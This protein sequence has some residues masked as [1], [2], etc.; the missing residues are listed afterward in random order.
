M[1]INLERSRQY[2]KQ[3]QLR[4]LFVEELGWDNYSGSSLSLSV[5][6]KTYTL[7]AIAEKRGQVVYTCLAEDGA[8]PISNIRT[9]IHKEACHYT[10]ENVLV[11]IDQAQTEQVWQWVRRD[12]GKPKVNRFHQFH[13]S[14]S[15]DALLQ[16]LETLAVSFDEEEQLTLVDVTRRTSRAFD[17]DRVTKKFYERFKKE[18][19]LFL[20]FIASIDSQFDREW[21]CSLMLNRLMFI[22]FIQKKGFLDGNTNYLRDRLQVCQK[23]Q[24]QDS[25][26]SFY[27]YFLLK[28]FHS[29]LGSQQRTP[30]LE[31]LL[32]G[33]PYLN[34]GLF[35][36]H[37][38]EQTYPDIQIPDKAFE[39]I[40]DFFDEYQWHL[41]DR[42]LR[43]DSEIN[44]DVLGYI[45]EK[46][47][48]QKQMGAYY[49]K[50]DITEYISK[51][52][53]LPF[54]FDA[55]Q[56]SC[57]IAFQ[58][59]RALWQLL[60]D[61]PDRYIYPAVQK[62]VDLPLPES[63]EVGVLDVTQRQGWNRPAESDYALPT[64]TWRE[65]ISRRQRCLELRQK[66][67]DGELHSI[68]DLITY[69]LDIRQFSQD[70][71][72]NSESPEFLKA[73]YTAICQVSIL[74][75][76]CGSGA[77]L[78]AALNIL[79]PLYDGCLERMQAS[80]DDLKRSNPSHHLNEFD[81]FRQILDRVAQHP[82]RRYFILKSIILN[83]LY[84]VD[85]MEEAT[86]ICKLRL[87]LKLVA[88]MEPQYKQPNFGLEPLP[89]IDFNIQ[90]GNTL[91][92]FASL[93]K[94]RKAIK[95][96]GDQFKL[97]LQHN[98]TR[99]DEN[100]EI[101]DRAF[102]RFRQMQ[103]EFCMDAGEFQDSKK[104]LRQQLAEVNKELNCYLARE[105]G[106]DLNKFTAFEKW[107]KSHQPFHW[108][109]EFYNIISRGGF[110]VIIGNPPYVEYK[111]V[112]N[113]YV[114]RD[115]ATIDCSDLYAFTIERSLELL[116]KS[117]RVG[118]IV[119]ISIVS[120]DGFDSLRKLLTEKKYF[121]W[122]LNFAERPSKL[123]TGVEKRLTIWITFKANE[124]IQIQSYVESYKRWLAEERGHLFS[125]IK[126]VKKT[127]SL[128]LVSNSIPKISSV[129]EG[130]I[131]E[132]LSGQKQ[133]NTFFFKSS[134][135]I[136]YYTRK[137][138]YFVQFYDFIPKIIN[139]QKETIEPSE[140]KIIAFS[141]ETYKNM[142]IS[143]LNSNLFFW[144]FNSYSDVRNVN[145]REIDKF[146]FSMN[147]ATSDVSYRLC[148][149]TNKLMQDFQ[150]NSQEL[151][152]NYGKYGTLTIQSFQPRLSKPIIDE[153]DRVLAQH[154][155]F[156]AEE[157]DF[158]INYDIKY[159]MGQ[160]TGEEE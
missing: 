29:G 123:F 42:P 119:P 6:G 115:F 93:D 50:E 56:K 55:V 44:P 10:L 155:G 34:G 131:L 16:K 13:K 98:A 66:L 114:I 11:Y 62:G 138:R 12:P 135:H 144:F 84:G 32:G 41:D 145:R 43:E 116:Y 73:F 100:A 23:L 149:L 35:E 111:N 139:A 28:L 21:Y 81:D 151:T 103:T 91:V 94:A 14:Q 1:Q 59:D 113:D 22:Y 152:N 132:R 122:S 141:S 2:L 134:Q 95:Q 72:E 15:G 57:A 38:L 136:V 20:E 142:A 96:D 27:R 121:S 70:A 74:D 9:K 143:I 90:A 7:T 108:F 154:Y 129:I 71:I 24:G 112:K 128:N 107:R 118:M 64:E 79:E 68:N 69:N 148:S 75:P 146:R 17:L 102:Q 76:T 37:Q 39:N 67:A 85:I 61:N 53:I 25:F 133:L 105:Y 117:G 156:T 130:S 110:D 26:H 51:N 36:V 78:F 33:V 31:Q 65:H 3:F 46:Y 106:V 160:D 97:D 153:I 80:L 125:Q 87:F 83:N 140:L 82:N 86:E 52:T 47:I 89:D 60:K 147:E 120:T 49:T 4:S 109:V 88:Q 54:L 40:F 101:A 157:L 77:F 8:I 137:L 18:H 150:K 45:F 104:E 48:N 30:E 158:I 63:I 19:G 92:G 126:F 124:T 99:I 127:S 159:R 5:D 58:P